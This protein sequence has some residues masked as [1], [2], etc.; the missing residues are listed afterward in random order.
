MFFTSCSEEATLEGAKEV[1]IEISP[2][3]ISMVIGDTVA[4]TARVTN[5]SGDEINTPIEWSIDAED[6]AK[7]DSDSIGN[8]VVVAC[9]GSLG[10]TTKLRATLVNGMYAVTT[11]TVAA[12]GAQ[13]VVPESETMRTYRNGDAV[14]VDTVWFFVEPYAIVDD[15]KP[16]V[17]ITP[18]TAHKDDPATLE[19]ASDD[20]F[21]YDA[22]LHRVGVLVCPSRSKGEFNVTLTA[23]G[24]GDTASGTCVV[25]VGPTIKVGMWDPEVTGMT[26]PTGDQYYGFNYEIRKTI[27]INTETKVYARVM[28]EGARAEDIANAR[29]CYTWEI[30]SG[31]NVLVTGNTQEDN[32]YGFDA[33]LS[34]RSGIES[35][36]A[37]ILF[38]SPDPDAPE[39]RAYITVK[40]YDKDYPVNDIEISPADDSMTMDNLSATVGGNLEMNVSIDPITSLAYHRP[41]VTIADESVLQ[42][43][44]YEGTLMLF[45]GLKPGKTKV[46]L[47][48]MSITKS[49]YVTVND[50]I[51]EVTWVTAPTSLAA[52]QSESYEI[53]VR[54][55]SGQASTLPVSWKSSNTGV[56]SI[57]STTS[58]KATVTA[59]AAG[60]ATI[61]ASVTSASGKTLSVSRE[62]TVISGY[63]DINVTDDNY[64]GYYPNDSNN[65]KVGFYLSNDG[66]DIW[67]YTKKTLSEPLNGTLTASDF[68]DA[69]VGGSAA[70]VTD[71]N[72]KLTNGKATGTITLS[73]GGVTQKII[74]NN[75]KIDYSID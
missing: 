31:N 32:Q 11:V 62:V 23:G 47:K 63:S 65:S 67:I 66:K 35:G 59:K 1:Y 55:T 38:T 51:S 14:E 6:I 57:A 56:L 54:T 49:F 50:E 7:M 26:A 2:S 71:A 72:L 15:Y 36:E 52:G 39:M 44:S 34:L 27:D 5:L 4:V 16:S 10:K 46:T 42:Y 45:K 24:G 43:V 30:E 41:S 25:T 53:R 58:T 68:S 69:E 60:K 13:S 19:V 8:P 21:C 40:D 70:T 17:S 64:P 33:V 48:S 37:V 3:E 75:I 18:T 61:T 22:E 29:D 74:F 9:P 20:P 12:H 28:I 73:I